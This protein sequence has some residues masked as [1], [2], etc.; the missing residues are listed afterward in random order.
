MVRF[1]AQAWANWADWSTLSAMAQLLCHSTKVCFL[2][3]REIYNGCSLWNGDGQGRFCLPWW[4]RL[5]W[6]NHLPIHGLFNTA[7]TMDAPLISFSGFCCPFCRRSPS[8]WVRGAQT[9]CLSYLD[10]SYF[11]S[12]GTFFSFSFNSQPFL[13][14]VAHRETA[15]I[16][17]R[18]MTLDYAGI[19]LLHDMQP[20]TNPT[21]RRRGA[22]LK[23]SS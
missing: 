13:G 8:S 10:S 22:L 1:L 15:A 7:N 19:Y 6:I 9:A 18:M 5:L 12:D 11:G 17:V 14:A 16:S 21:V 3:L 4:C 23:S 2:L 20:V